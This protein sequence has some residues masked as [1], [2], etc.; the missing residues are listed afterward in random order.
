[1]GQFIIA[2]YC[3]SQFIRDSYCR[4][5]FIRDSYRMRGDGI[6]LKTSIPLKYRIVAYY[7]VLYNFTS[8]IDKI[9]NEL[10]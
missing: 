8:K 7:I 3:T 4:S 1:M 5:Q 9:E 2:N 6:V 10:L